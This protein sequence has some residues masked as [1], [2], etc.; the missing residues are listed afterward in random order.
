MRPGYC[1]VLNKACK[2][3]QV[4]KLLPSAPQIYSGRAPR[5]PRLLRTLEFLF[6]TG[7][8]AWHGFPANTACRG[9]MI[10]RLVDFLSASRREPVVDVEG[11]LT[12]QGN[13]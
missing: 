2:G 10:V 12:I 5:G 11:L 6:G 13:L 8:H 7:P 1:A 4:L 9:V 3:L